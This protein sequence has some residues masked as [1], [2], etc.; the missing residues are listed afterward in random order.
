MKLSTRGRYALR[1]MLD[2][3]KNDGEEKPVS[4]TAI[5]RRT[6]LSRGYLEQLALALR[7][8]KLLR[9]VSGRS[10]G[11]RLAR[12]AAQIS[13]GEIIEATIG[14][15]CLVD[16]LDDPDSCVKANNCECRLVYALINHRI[17]EVLRSFTL[18]DL[19]D[20]K[21]MSVVGRQL[22]EQ[23]VLTEVGAGRGSIRQSPSRSQGRVTWARIAPA[24]TPLRGGNAV[25]GPPP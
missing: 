14:P 16:C 9:G 20:P 19:L 12:P 2:L 1:M 22:E 7:M 15:V 24:A 11:Y 13:I 23:A 5:A 6:G 4:L 17:T 25:P 18:A 21:G 3:A 8:A 10:G